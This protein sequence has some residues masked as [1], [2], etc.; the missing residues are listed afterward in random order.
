MLS[1]DEI[2]IDRIT[3]LT[4]SLQ[5]SAI[6]FGGL[7]AEPIWTLP[8]LFGE[9][10]LF[11]FHWL[12]EYPYALPSLMNALALTATSVVVFLY[13]EEVRMLLTHLTLTTLWREADKYT[14]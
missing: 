11:G 12:H 6:V 7:L 8:G 1:A 13:L 10:A 9:G 14:T 2:H 3:T 4:G 5:C